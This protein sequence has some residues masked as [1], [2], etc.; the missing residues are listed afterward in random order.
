MVPR[1]NTPMFVHVTDVKNRDVVLF[2][3]L[4]EAD[5]PT[6]PS[7]EACARMQFTQM[8]GKG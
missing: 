8:Q 4:A 2:V 1:W 3:F 5:F 7:R 6:A